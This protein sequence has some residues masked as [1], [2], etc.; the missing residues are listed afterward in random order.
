MGQ[1]DALWLS[2]VSSQQ[3]KELSLIR[4]LLSSDEVEAGVFSG[5]TCFPFS[6]QYRI[7]LAPVRAKH[8]L[9]ESCLL[10]GIDTIGHLGTQSFMP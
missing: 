10:D 5:S 9:R 7:S 2:S 3:G 6:F 1:P 8:L 4:A